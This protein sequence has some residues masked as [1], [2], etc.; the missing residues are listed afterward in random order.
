MRE[1]RFNSPRYMKIEPKPDERLLTR[2]HAVLLVYCSGKEYTTDEREDIIRYLI[3]GAEA[4]LAKDL[5]WE[6]KRVERIFKEIEGI[7]RAGQT[8]WNK[9][10]LAY[11]KQLKK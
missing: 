7:I 5:E 11:W 4:Q 6:A 10:Q 3:F 2:E 1:L 8:Q 9:A